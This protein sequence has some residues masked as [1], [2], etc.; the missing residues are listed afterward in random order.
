[1]FTAFVNDE[2]PPVQTPPKATNA[3]AGAAAQPP[4]L[5]GAAQPHANGIVS[6]IVRHASAPQ[7]RQQAG[8]AGANQPTAK[9]QR[10]EAAP[11]QNSARQLSAGPG[12]PGNGAAASRPPGSPP[13]PLTPP[14]KPGEAEP[15]RDDMSI[16]SDSQNLYADGAAEPGDEA[17]S[18]PLED[19]LP[20]SPDTP[21]ETPERAT[22]AVPGDDSAAAASVQPASAAPVAVPGLHDASAP[23]QRQRSGQPSETA[24]AR[25]AAGGQE[26]ATSGQQGNDAVDRG[27]GDA[28]TSGRKIHSAYRQAGPVGALLRQRRLCLVL[29]LDHT[30]VNSAKFSEVEPEHLK[31]SC[32]CRHHL[33]LLRQLYVSYQSEEIGSIYTSGMGA[34]WLRSGSGARMR[35]LVTIVPFPAQE[36]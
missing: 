22:P 31:V 20:F 32:P 5:S 2:T 15:D 34:S 7:K 11:Q 1:M 3:A 14:S 24:A 4:G 27:S 28:S 10:W 25:A 13:S 30:L 29:D 21:S 12:K 19:F 9:R 33:L 35:E 23:P 17:A 6:P 16:L 36:E 26:G 8:A 18:K